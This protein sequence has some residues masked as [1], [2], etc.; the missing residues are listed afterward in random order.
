MVPLS[1]HQRR[2]KVDAKW[3]GASGMT[4]CWKNGVNIPLGIQAFLSC[5][6]MKFSSF[7]LMKLEGQ[8][9]S[10]PTRADI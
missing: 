6:A 3:W 7:F 4:E 1:C 10:L 8:H 2:E 5:E 9:Q